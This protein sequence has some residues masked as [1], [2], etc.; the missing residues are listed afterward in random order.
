MALGDDCEICLIGVTE[1]NRI[2]KKTLP[3]QVDG[4]DQQIRKVN[5]ASPGLVVPICSAAQANLEFESPRG[6]A[7]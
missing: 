6:V 7:P 1:G 4:C 5:P 3:P 2:V